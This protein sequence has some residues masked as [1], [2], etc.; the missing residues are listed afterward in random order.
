MYRDKAMIDGAMIAEFIEIGWFVMGK[1]YI[2]DTF[3]RERLLLIKVLGNYENEGEAEQLS[4]EEQTMFASMVA[5]VLRGRGVKSA[6][7]YLCVYFRSVGFEIVDAELIRET[8]EIEIVGEHSLAS[9]WNIVRLGTH[10]MD[11]ETEES[12]LKYL[13]TKLS[14]ELFLHVCD[15]TISRLC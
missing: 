13:A 12:T 11:S 8:L 7:I 4:A 14:P 9:M 1:G 5:R 2:A 6:C 15:I 3:L 10:L